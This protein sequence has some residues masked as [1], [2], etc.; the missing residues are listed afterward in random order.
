MRMTTYLNFN[1]DCE[2]AFRFYATVFGGEIIELMRFEGSPAAEHVPADWHGKVMHVGLT[3]GD[4]ILMGSDGMPERYDPPQGFAVSLQLD[5]EPTEAER[6]FNALADS[7]TVT[8]PFTE[9]FWALRF[10]M[11]TDRFGTPWMI[12]CNHPA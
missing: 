5:N 10:G 12:N 8:M 9:T 11:V 7:G 4:E 2:D 3:I 6:L 1:G